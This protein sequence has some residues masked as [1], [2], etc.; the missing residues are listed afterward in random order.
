MLTTTTTP[1]ATIEQDSSPLIDYDENPFFPGD[2]LSMFPDDFGNE[3]ETSFGLDD[4]T[5]GYGMYNSNF[6]S[7]APVQPQQSYYPGAMTMPAVAQKQAPSTGTSTP[8]L[9][10]EQEDVLRLRAIA[11]PSH[12]GSGAQSRVHSPT[13]SLSSSSSHDEH[14]R[15]PVTPNR[16][17]SPKKRKSVDLS[18]SDSDLE[19]EVD[20]APKPK[21]KKTA[22]NQIEKRYR[23]NL[24]DKICDL[25]YSVP[26]LRIL[27][28]QESNPSTP[29]TVDLEGLQPATKLNKATILAKAVEYIQH[30]ERKNEML[31]REKQGLF[32]RVVAFEN[33]LVVGEERGCGFHQMQQQQQPQYAQMQGLRMKGVPMQRPQRY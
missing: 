7:E 2:E 9:K 20:S 11:M 12:F 23:N 19:D 13:P 24:N 16:A 30:L 26:T 17:S 33:L 27:M 22:H 5:S 8:Y 21:S 29:H 4:T 28:D 31:R 10:L 6:E 3:R 14:S 15:S 25:K 18:C 32:E 1:L